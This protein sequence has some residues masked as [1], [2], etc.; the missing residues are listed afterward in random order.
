M[1]LTEL[2]RPLS[3]KNSITS[4]LCSWHYIALF[5]P[6]FTSGSSVSRK[7]NDRASWHLGIWNANEMR[8]VCCF[9]CG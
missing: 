3:Y 8:Y 1:K 4:A 7:I 6:T 5:I 2:F 9:H